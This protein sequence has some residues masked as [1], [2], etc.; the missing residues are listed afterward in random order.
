M[1]IAYCRKIGKEKLIGKIFLKKN[2]NYFAQYRENN[3]ELLREKGKE[4]YANNKKKILERQKKHRQKPEVKA[5][6]YLYDKHY[7]E[8]HREAELAKK[9]RY[10]EK[11]RDEINAKKRMSRA[12][13]AS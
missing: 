2:P 12:K 6:R 7:R 4:Y 13:K 8:T 5:Q 11:H 1:R 10:R 9:K 3:R